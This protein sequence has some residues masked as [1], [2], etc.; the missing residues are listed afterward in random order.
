[1]KYK[2]FGNLDFKKLHPSGSLSKQLKSVEDLMIV[3]NKIPF[4]S[5]NETLNKGLKIIN[6]KKLGTVVIRN[7][8]NNTTGI[9]TDGDIKRL[10]QKY[11]NIKE[12]KLKNIRKKK[13]ISVD[14]DLL[15][16]KALKIMNDKKIT[17]L[18]VHS[19]SDKNKTIGLLHI[20]HILEANIN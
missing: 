10:I 7:K 20:H 12:I 5:E 13:P 17:S 14:K 8:K 2:K 4:I 1:M 19:R 3:K 15:A 6:L 9:I 18:C 11:D 16:A